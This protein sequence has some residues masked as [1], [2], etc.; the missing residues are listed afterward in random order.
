MLTA[1]IQA[2]MQQARYELIEDEEPYYGEVTDL[3]GVW[4]TGSTLEA[5]RQNLVEAVEDWL[6]LSIARGLPVPSLGDV[7]I[8][9]PARVPA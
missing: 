7:T 8:R 5:C 4:A 1:Y 3:E 9:V 2:A 6:L